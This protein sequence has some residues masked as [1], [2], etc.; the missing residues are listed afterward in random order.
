MIKAVVFDLDN[1]LYDY[2]TYNKTAE[3][4]LF[5]SMSE[6]FD[7]SI[8]DAHNLLSQAKAHIKQLGCVAASHNRL[9]YMQN[10]CEQMGK[11]PFEYAMKLYYCYWDTILELMRPFDYVMPLFKYLKDKGI[12]IAILTDM[13]AHIQ[14]RKI[15]R[16]GLGKYIDCIVTSEEAGAEKPD[17]KMFKCII[18]KLGFKPNEIL[19]IGDSLCK[20]VD[21]AKTAGMKAILYEEEEKLLEAINS[22]AL[23]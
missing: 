21:G 22:G 4:R 13:T 20:D 5:H 16:L 11:S 14:Y 7:I 19:M 12:K 3:E 18:D 23:L 1:T 9:L 8:C 15:E 2:D 17:V 10:I 6:E